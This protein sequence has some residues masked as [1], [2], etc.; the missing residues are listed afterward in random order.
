MQELELLLTV[1]RSQVLEIAPFTMKVPPAPPSLQVSFPVGVVGLL[2]E[3]VTVPLRATAPPT[4]MYG[5]L[6]FMAVTVA[7]AAYTVGAET[8]S[9]M[10]ATIANE[11]NIM[12]GTAPFLPVTSILFVPALSPALG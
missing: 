5:R 11:T 10:T 7:L 6:D 4:G 8:V 12:G 9:A 3:S 1:F 2:L